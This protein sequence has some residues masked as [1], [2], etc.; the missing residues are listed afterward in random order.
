MLARKGR[1]L[2]AVQDTYIY[3]AA[4]NAVTGEKAQLAKEGGTLT[5]KACMGY[6]ILVK[7]KKIM[8]VCVTASRLR[9]MSRMNASSCEAR[10]SIC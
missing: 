2:F 8:S 3:C 7:F 9:R 4:P 6:F 10:E 1:L 5:L